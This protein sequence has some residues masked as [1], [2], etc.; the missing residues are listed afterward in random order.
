METIDEQLDSALAQTRELE[1]QLAEAN[2]KVAS[3]EAERAA[4]ETANAELK[5]NL[6]ATRDKLAAQELATRE[7]LAQVDLLKAEAK[8]AEQRAADIYGAQAGAP[9]AVT[10]KGDA[11]KVPVL[12]RFKAI[13]DPAS[14]TLFL[15]SLS[16]SERNELFSNL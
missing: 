11:T 13:S 14:Q 3:L 10:P 6:Q 7:A 12:Q 2:A 1:A 5:D 15:R 8:T 4:F 16:E 9:V